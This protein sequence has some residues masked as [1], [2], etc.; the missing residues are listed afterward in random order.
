MQTS[1]GN[2]AAGS[3][4]AEVTVLV[5]EDDWDDFFLLQ[6]AFRKAGLSAE[7]HWG[8]NGEQAIAFLD[9]A[10]ARGQLPL[11]VILDLRLPVMDGFEVLACIRA[12]P[13]L[14]CLPVTVFTSSQNPQDIDRAYKLGATAFVVKPCGYESLVKVSQRLWDALLHQPEAKRSLLV[15]GC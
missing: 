11:G 10:A 13:S 2:G 1:N 8:Q 3:G 14:Q 9:A 12:H 4:G 5:V 15:A 6:R 7:L